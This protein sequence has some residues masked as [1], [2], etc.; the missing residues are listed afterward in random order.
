MDTE[1]VSKTDNL[2]WKWMEWMG[3]GV[4]F[5]DVVWEGVKKCGGGD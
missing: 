5:G 2:R 1:T 4:V 3:K